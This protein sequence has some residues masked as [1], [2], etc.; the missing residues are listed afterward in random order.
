MSLF[1]IRVPAVLL[2]I[3]RNPFHHGTLGA[4]RSLGRAGVDVHVVAES[5][6][7]PVSASRFVTQ[8]HP[9]PPPGAR[10]DEIVLALRRVAARVARPAVLIPMD[11]A[12]AL[13]VGA[14]R[15][16]L[17]PAYLLP[18]TPDRVPARVAD[19]AELADLCADLD[20]PHPSTIVPES[21]AEAA[22]AAWRLGLPLV[23]KWSR[24]WLLPAGTGLRSTMVV[25]SAREARELFHRSGEAGSRLLLQAFL[26]PGPESDWFFHGY[27]DRAGV[28]RGGGTG[29]K[30]LAWPR[31][32][33]LTAVG[34]WTPN[35]RVAALAERLVA[36]LGYR[37]IL[38]L[39]FRRGPSGRHHLLDFNPRPGAQFRLFADS[40]GLDVVRALHLDLTHRPLPAGRALAGREF[41]VENY[42]P[43]AALRPAAGSRELAWHADDDR[44][45]GQA[46]RRLWT[47][48]A[49]RR[50]WTRL[51]PAAPAA[52][53]P[54]GPG[55]A[56]PA[57]VP[58]PSDLSDD[59]RASSC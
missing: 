1:D 12:S 8:S 16:A 35:P 9:P 52:P 4:V 40:A 58:F 3:D 24:P 11:D 37:G 19:K 13:A 57:P 41:V 47:R 23:A 21:P 38:D 6:N 53:R 22:T 27:A 30:L 36:E 34:R 17:A 44:G 15:D 54:T 50:L 39:D 51:G 18:E 14:R 26:P 25:H 56:V 29:V 45:P 55:P 7:S 43:L 42:A 46:L 48:H 32:A 28:L 2:R 10:A 5:G 59:E 20:V 49:A 33:G 31:G